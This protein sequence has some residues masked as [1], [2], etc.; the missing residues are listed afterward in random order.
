MAILRLPSFSEELRY[1]LSNIS[2]AGIVF[3]VCLLLIQPQRVVR[4]SMAILV[5]HGPLNGFSSNVLK[6]ATS[7]A[8]V[9]YMYEMLSFPLFFLYRTVVLSNSTAWRECFNKRNMLVM[10][11][12]I[13]I[14]CCLE[15]SCLFFADIPYE[16]LYERL[17]KTTNITQLFGGQWEAA[18]NFNQQGS[19]V[20]HAT[21]PGYQ[22]MAGAMPMVG[23]A[24]KRHLPLLGDDYSRNPLII[25]FHGIAIVSHI[26]AFLVIL[27]SA[28][29]MTSILKKKQ[30]TMSLDALLANEVMLH[31]VLPEA[32][33]P[34][35]L[36]VP[37]A[38]NAVLVTLYED[39]LEW[40]ELFPMYCVSLVPLLSPAI[41]IYFIKAYRESLLHFLT[42]GYLRATPKGKDEQEAD[43]HDEGI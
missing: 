5:P 38:T 9:S 13:F 2:I 18:D 1:F 17:R 28:Y 37:V 41:S 43:N 33:L 6:L 26:I 16:D 39:S 36:A 31:A 20:V 11:T 25:Y 40:Q 32:L 24:T 14:F 42:F 29:C 27:I 7:S 21:T 19:D 8:V 3:S 23:E 30:A 34:L 22:T 35:V 15:G 10:F 4:G 12:I